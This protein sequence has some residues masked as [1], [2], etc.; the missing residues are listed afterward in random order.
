M[1]SDVL[2]LAKL[3]TSAARDAMITYAHLV[4]ECG[5][6]P[7]QLGVIDCAFRAG[8]LRLDHVALLY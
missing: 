8:K 5:D 2:R 4:Q 6:V 1:N 7:T 3:M